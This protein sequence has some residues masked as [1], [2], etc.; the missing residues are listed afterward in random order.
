MVRGGGE[1]LRPC[2]MSGEGGRE[3]VGGRSRVPGGRKAGKQWLGG[4][5]GEDVEGAGRRGMAAAEG[6]TDGGRRNQG[7]FP[8]TGHG[9]SS[10]CD[11]GSG[12][13]VRAVFCAFDPFH[14]S[15]KNFFFIF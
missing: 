5:A 8:A 15:S 4:E 11:K 10:G 12:R 9:R 7:S 14:A 6:G 13:T 3:R 2:L 1:E